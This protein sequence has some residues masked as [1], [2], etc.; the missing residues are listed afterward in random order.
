MDIN[1][2]LNGF[3]PI[4]DFN[5][6]LQK[7]LSDFK[8]DKNVLEGHVQTTIPRAM[9]LMNDQEL[10]N[11]LKALSVQDSSSVGAIDSPERLYKTFTD[12][13]NKG[14]NSVNNANINAEKAV[15]TFAAGGN[16]DVHSVMI[17]SEKAHLNMQL[18]MQL[19]NKFVQAYQE[20]S[21]LQV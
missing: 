7:E 8:L 17:A 16:I 20:I 10:V 5:N 14:I 18:A 11:D 12:A 6:S 3:N 1:V 13:L 15:E 21:R 4:K 2:G 19:R 9:D